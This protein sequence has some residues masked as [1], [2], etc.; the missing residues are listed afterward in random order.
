MRVVDCQVHLHRRTYFEAH[1]ER[2]EPPWAER[3]NGGY[4]F[5]TP[6]GGRSRIPSAHYEIEA[7]MERCAAHG[8]DVVVSSMGRFNVHHLPAGRA[9]DLAMQLNEEQAELERSYPGRYYGLALLPMQDAQ[10][11]IEALDHAVRALGLRGVCICSNVNGESIAT[12]ARDPIYGRIEKLGVPIFLHPTTSAMEP[13][14][15]RYS[16]ED[17]VGCMVDSSVA[18]LDLIFSG[19]LDRHPTLRV[20]HPHLG[21][22]LPYLASR[23]D[24]AHADSPSPAPLERRPSD[25]LRRFHTDT[26]CAG[27]GALR[28]AAEVYGPERLLYAS[29]CPRRQAA[30]DLD[31]VRGE[32][33]GEARDRVLHGN[34]ASLLGLGVAQTA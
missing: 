4:V 11:A 15:M 13:L 29:D 10:A 3:S 23:I 18:A 16:H 31:V 27:Q 28:M 5:R 33:G 21:G 2:V 20:V 14:L 32:F 1:V 34:A 19:L 7:Q 17:T 26:A 30:A 24:D 25:Y 8:V 22:V 12:P 6:G 9:L